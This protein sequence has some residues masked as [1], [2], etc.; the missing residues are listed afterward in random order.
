MVELS[1]WKGI[2]VPQRHET[3]CIPTGFEWMIRYLG[4]KGINLEAFQ[5]DFDLQRRNEGDNSFVPIASKIKQ[6]YPQVNIKIRD[7]PSGNEKIAFLRRLVES[8]TP[9]IMSIAKPNGGWHIV[10]V[11]S[12]DDRKINVIWVA[13]ANGNQISEYP[14]SEITF[15]HDNWAGGKDIAWFGN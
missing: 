3:G 6:K 8:N 12:V 7:F 14:I 13:N 11:V 2:V 1:H 4:M 15:R 9:C 10:P 5:E